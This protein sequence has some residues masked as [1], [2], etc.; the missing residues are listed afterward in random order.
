MMIWDENKRISN[1]KK[2]GIDFLD[3]SELWNNLTVTREDM[4]YSYLEQRFITLG[5]VLN[6]VAVVIHTETIDG[7]VRLISAR[8]ATRYERKYYYSKI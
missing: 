8:K 1:L 7:D 4:R 6:G 3:C 2:H 5:I